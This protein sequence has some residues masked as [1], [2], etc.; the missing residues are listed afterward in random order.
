MRRE[1]RQQGFDEVDARRLVLLALE[2]GYEHVPP[3]ALAPQVRLARQG[4]LGAALAEVERAVLGLGDLRASG[5]EAAVCRASLKDLIGRLTR[6][7]EEL[8][9][10]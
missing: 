9:E 4:G 6:L 10:T 7:L 3:P 2:P 8:E 5:A 1:A